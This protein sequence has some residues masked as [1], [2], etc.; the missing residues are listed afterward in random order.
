MP[1]SVRRYAERTTRSTGLRPQ[2]VTVKEC[3]GDIIIFF[4]ISHESVPN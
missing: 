3:Q 4:E 1:F 2:C